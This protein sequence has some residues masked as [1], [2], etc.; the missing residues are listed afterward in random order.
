MDGCP[1]Q[2][3]LAERMTTALRVVREPKL[4]RR[5]PRNPVSV[6]PL[7]SRLQLAR[8]MLVL[9]CGF[10]ISL[11]LELV[12]IS[13]LHEHAEQQRAFALF[14][15]QLAAGTAPIGPADSQGRE[16]QRGSPV[17]F[18]E[19]PSIG[20]RQVVVEGTT[21][22]TLFAG[23]GHRRDT[24]LPGQAGISVVLGRRGAFGAPF[25]EL[26]ELKPGA[27]IR[28][29]TGNGAFEYRVTGIRRAGDPAPPIPA[30]GA[31][32][33]LLATATG[34]RFI[35]SGVLRVD[36]TLALPAVNGP[37]RLLSSGA[38]PAPEQMMAGDPTNLDGLVLSLQALIL[39][40]LAATWAWHRW[41]GVK[42]WVMFLTPMLIASLSASSAAARLLPNLL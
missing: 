34:A 5:V 27:L 41:S 18:L 1:S 12:V 29:T 17:A 26:Q 20:L 42:A 15:A 16:L 2:W 4:L 14:R 11:V 8:A 37:R 10:S 36:A 22:E 23:P 3:P 35:P 21:A 24:P 6:P 13:S 32:R 39:V 28:A 30:A 19:I 33:L 7:S 31:S 25:A 9:L 38:L 40:T